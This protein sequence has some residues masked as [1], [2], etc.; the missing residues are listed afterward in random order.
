MIAYIISTTS[1][2]PITRRAIKI[3]VPCR[4]GKSR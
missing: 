4:A 2:I 3:I 1:D